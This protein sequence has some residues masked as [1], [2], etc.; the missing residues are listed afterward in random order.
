MKK[1]KR[2][3][4]LFG[5][6]NQ[7]SSNINHKKTQS[8]FLKPNFAFGNEQNSYNNMSSSK[9]QFKIDAVL[10]DSKEINEIHNINDSN[11]ES[12]DESPK[13]Y[14]ATT[15]KK[16]DLKEQKKKHEQ[17]IIDNILESEQEI[18]DNDYETNHHFVKLKLDDFIT[19][20][21]TLFSIITGIMYHDFTNYQQSSN[22]DASTMNLLRDLNLWLTSI[23]VLLFILCSLNRYI[24]LLRLNKSASMILKN[25]SFWSCDYFGSFLIETVFA[26]LHPNYFT[27]DIKFT[28][29]KIYY[30][31][32]VEYEVND[33]L[34]IILILRVYV[35]FR[36]FISFSQFY[37]A[38]SARVAKLIGSEVNRLF[39]IKCVVLVNPFLFLGIC[40]AI[41]IISTSY[42]L[43]I[44]EGSAFTNEMADN[45]Y[46]K[47]LNCIWNVIVTMTTVGYG[48]YYPI[49]NLGRLVNI[50]VS[51]WGTFLTSLMVVALQSLLVFTDL[52]D[53]AFYYREKQ[54]LKET[55]ERRT[56]K[57]FKAAFGYIFAKKKYRKAC[58]LGY[59]KE[60]QDKLKKKIE[61]ALYKRIGA[62]RVF[63]NLF[64]LYRNTY[65]VLNESDLLKEKMESFQAQLEEIDENCDVMER[66]IDRMNTILDE[67][68]SGKS[69][70]KLSI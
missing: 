43:R 32:E 29:K 69:L 14:R 28:T 52:Q 10:H 49:T 60:K 47:F 27:K 13:S 31:I 38:R 55:F 68:E 63:K 57:L 61:E 3:Q 51:I 39:V 20:Y 54:Q 50:F 36:F 40:T 70:T 19:A 21:L 4:S 42:I 23:F 33:M 22:V 34:L 12:N 66:Y 44:T 35:I 8:T 30:M 56:A 1:K 26:L 2:I 18:C 5:N 6:I 53:K 48:D 11:N 65:E 59:S 58:E 41:L 37:T 25:T 64:Q 62:W 7:E 16:I 46:R 15:F 67:I 9:D 17:N 24:N 45:D